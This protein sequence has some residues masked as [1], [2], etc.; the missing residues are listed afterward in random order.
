M[1]DSLGLK[2]DPMDHIRSL[3]PFSLALIAACAGTIR[4]GHVTKYFRANPG[5]PFLA[6]ES[7]DRRCPFPGLSSAAVRMAFG[8]PSEVDSGPSLVRWTFV[9]K[10]PGPIVN[11]TLSD[12]TVIGW[13]ANDRYKWRKVPAPPGGFDWPRSQPRVV[14]AYLAEHPATSDAETYAMARGCPQPGMAPSMI[15]A[16]WGE[17]VL[18][19]TV[20]REDG[21]RVRFTYGFGVEGQST[22]LEFT[23]DSLMVGRYCGWPTELPPECRLPS[24]AF[25]GLRP[26]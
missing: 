17:P 11:I 4:E 3:W 8:R 9:L 24:T 13:T 10:Q 7:I 5:L 2:P 26:N 1:R 15:A 20:Q 21:V 18:V 23:R 22:Q 12:D 16:M 25:R 19:D 14:N 6:R